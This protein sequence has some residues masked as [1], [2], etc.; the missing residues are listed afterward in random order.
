M[1][2]IS[3]LKNHLIPIDK[4]QLI[5]NKLS[6]ETNGYQTLLVDRATYPKIAIITFNR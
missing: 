4:K 3:I 6:N 2:R 1:K 5:V